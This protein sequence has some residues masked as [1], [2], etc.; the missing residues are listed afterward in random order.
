M[1]SLRCKFKTNRQAHKLGAYIFMKKILKESNDN[2]KCRFLH[3]DFKS[4]Q[5]SPKPYRLSYQ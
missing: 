1:K 4:M 3:F 2:S 5:V